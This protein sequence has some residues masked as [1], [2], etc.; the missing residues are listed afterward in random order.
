MQA[1][2]SASKDGEFD[3]PTQFTAASIAA[4]IRVNSETLGATARQ[5]EWITRQWS[6]A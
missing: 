6:T 3:C 4:S 1:F 5:W 2:A